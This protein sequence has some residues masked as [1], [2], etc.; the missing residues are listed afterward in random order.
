M[1]WQTTTALLI[2]AAA[3]WWLVKKVWK[4]AQAVTGNG[5]IPDCG[6]CAK[7][8]TSTNRNESS[9]RDQVI[10]KIGGPVPRD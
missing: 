3:A 2:V 8:A 4:V 7:N 5:R 10:V 9:D 6:N 1:D